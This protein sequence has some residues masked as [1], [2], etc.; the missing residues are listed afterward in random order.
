MLR[1]FSKFQRSRTVFLFAFCLL[2]L[3]GLVV[4]YLPNTDL[5]PGTNT[6][7]LSAD[8][9]IIVA[10]VGSQEITLEEFKRAVASYAQRYTRQNQLP[11]ATLKALGADKEALDGL[12]ANRLALD[13]GNELGLRGTDHEISD[14]VTRAFADANGQFVGKAE[15]IRSLA[16]QGKAPADYEEEIRR[17][18]TANK[19]RNYLMAGEQVSDKEI[20]E[21][22]K[23]DNTKVEVSYAII[24]R[25][26]VKS[27]L[28]ATDEELK[29]YY[30]ANKDRFKADKPTRKVDY[31]YVST[32]QVAKIMPVTDADLRAEYDSNKQYEYRASII[33]RDVLATADEDS[34]RNKINELNV[35][36]RGSQSAKAE[37]FAT[38]AKAESQDASRTSGGDIGFIRKDPNKP[39]AW[40]Q[41]V[42]SIKV[43]DIDG[44]FRDG[45]SWYLL[46]VTEQREVPFEAMKATL[47]AGVANRKAY[48]KASE[49]A[50]KAYAEATAAKS[51]RKGAEAIAAE[52]KQPVDA[53][54]RTTPYFK[55]GDTLP[56]IGSNPAFEEAVKDLKKGDIT[57]KVGIP[58]GLAVPQLADMLAEGAAL[59]FEQAKN[60]VENKWR[61]E[62]EPNV[63]LARAQDI[64]AKA[65]SA[66]EFS[67]LCKAEGLEVKSDTNFN[68]L[69]FPGQASGGLQSQQVA[70]NALFNLKA[71]EVVKVPIKYGAGGFLIFAAS[72]R[73]EADMS[74]IGGS[75][76]DL[77]QTLVSERQAIAFDAYVKAARKRYE[78]AGKLKIYQ[79]RIDKGMEGA[80]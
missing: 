63:A 14:Q 64:L 9:K 75:R 54:L 20:E 4:F 29:A 10:T 1:F 68:N 73:D 5:M 70:R 79:D 26:K 41:R 61:D 66:A 76:D 77:R 60:Q 6:A 7:A 22:Y 24:D 34:V 30:D 27:K 37:D 65:K 16:L 42:F 2:L 18:L 53:L 19:V 15:Y 57:E 46:K 72:K 78:T 13:V 71:N 47:R 58:G 3:V 21:S 17:N 69:T 62:K 50:D 8:A 49:L 44:P 28:K 31:I 55:D 25:E 52:I 35:R 43:G 45:Q 51:L 40:R 59:S 36:V 74:K 39:G 12:I 11:F 38:V 67:A 48:G 23:K 80:Q 33:R 56:E 32:D